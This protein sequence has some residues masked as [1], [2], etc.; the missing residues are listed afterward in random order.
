MNLIKP[1][2]LKKGDTIALL[3]ASGEI[4]DFDRIKKAEKYFQNSGYKTKISETT[5]KKFRYHAGSDEERIAEIEE[6]F[7]NKNIDAIVCTR[8]GYGLLRIV[9]KLDYDLI[10][11]NPKI[12]CG[13]SDITVLLLMFYK[14]ANLVSF[15]GAM[16]NGDFGAEKLSQFTEKSFFETLTTEKPLVF[17]SKK[18]KVLNS[19][20]V[21]NA[22]LWGGN[23]ATIVS[24]LGGANFIPDEKFV[25]FAEDVNEPAYKID[26]MFT[27]LMR[28]EKF[29]KNVAGFAIGQFSGADK[30][31]FVND[32]ISEYAK[33]LNIPAV[34]DFAISHDENK[35]T[36]PIGVKC[37]FNSEDK[38]ISLLESPFSD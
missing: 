38:S 12:F 11:K 29:V 32:V 33:N 2:K 35:Y 16:A 17:S 15:H 5:F 7:S 14:K 24:M 27:Q 1:K 36:L 23:L 3:S 30:P 28:N 4:R 25:F 37:S 9:D 21:E 20:S 19:G 8:G 22:V 10:A 18:G 31:N 26:R 34:N 13:Y 6:L